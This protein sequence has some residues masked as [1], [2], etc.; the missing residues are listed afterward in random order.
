MIKSIITVFMTSVCLVA[1][2]QQLPLFTQYRENL[3]IINPAAV[4]SDFLIYKQPTNFGISYRKQWA[5]LDAAPTTQIIRGEHFMAYNG[6]RTSPIFG[7]HII[8]D[9]TGPLAMTGITGKIA[10]V[11]SDDPE[12]Y[13]ISAG[14]SASAV[15][16]SF[17][18]SKV[19]VRDANDI[20]ITNRQSQIIP[21]VGLGVY[22]WQRFSGRGFFDG[23][24][25]SG[26]I[27]VPQTV[28]FNLAFKDEN[29]KFNIKRVQHFYGQASLVHFFDD[30]E[31]FIEPSVWLK[32]APN[33]PLNIDFNLRYLLAPSIWV[34]AGASSGGNF[35]AETGFN[36]GENAG[37]NGNLKVGYG[38]DYSF[39]PAGPFFGSTH[40]I[41]LTYSFGGR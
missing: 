34:G 38:Y 12:E 18:P 29:G 9:Q 26:G 8:N 1:Y 5:E 31:K 27:S 36:I 21:D 4:H 35:H 3:G 39:S 23:D 6:T 20:D 33:A 11:I 24:I 22:A 2:S 37:F 25:V 16:H 14:L 41:N 19:R 15:M 10:V 30:E 40:E 32:Y 17:N 13:G 28:G 7:G